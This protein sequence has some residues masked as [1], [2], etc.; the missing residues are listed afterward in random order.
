MFFGVWMGLIKSDLITYGMYLEFQVTDGRIQSLNRRSNLSGLMVTT[1]RP[2]I[3]GSML[4]EVR[5]QYLHDV[6][7]LIQ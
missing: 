4:L 3:T 7:T 2:T 6:F 1:S 5:T